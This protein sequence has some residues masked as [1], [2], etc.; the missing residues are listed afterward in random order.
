MTVRQNLLVAAHSIAGH[1]AQRDDLIRQVL[2]RCDLLDKSER[3]AGSLGLLDLKRLEVARALSLRPRLLLLD[4]VAAGLVGVEVQEVTQLIASVQQQGVTIL[5]VEHVQ[6][7]IQ[8]LATRVIVLDQGRT[9]AEGTPP[10]IAR[11]PRVVAVYLGTEK[12]TPAPATGAPFQ[13]APAPDGARRAVLR[14]DDVSVD[15]GK[16]RA[17]QAV[18]FEVYDG[19]VV[20]L[21]GA[22]GAGKSTL[23]WAMAGLVPLRGGQV[24]LDGSDMTRLPPHQRARQGIA[25]CHEGR[26]LFTQLTVRE[27]LEL[28]AAYASRSATP[29]K[30]R[31]ARIYQLF[32]VLVERQTTRAGRLSGGQQQM[33]AIGRALMADPR[34]IIFDELSLGLVPQAIDRIYEAIGQLRAWGVSARRPARGPPQSSIRRVRIVVYAA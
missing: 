6:A 2:E 7:L 28:G 30:T 27:N 24:R 23:A 20:A 31:L 33:V 16:L 21:L 15:Y 18:D 26:R 19:E 22:N 12:S 1:R 4:E 29:L 32:P 25:L 17:V 5:L 13:G 11:D 9:L 34:L 14:L 3:L 10:E 8:A